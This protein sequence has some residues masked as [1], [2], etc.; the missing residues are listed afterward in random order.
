M[1][2][3]RS[4]GINWSF[5]AALAGLACL[6]TVF[7]IGLYIG[8]LN[9]PKEE[10]YQRYR[11]A[12]NQPTKLEVA[13]VIPK[14]ESF[15]YKEPCKNP[16]GRDESDLCAQWKAARAAERGALW[17]ER[18]VWITLVGAVGLFLTIIQGR[19]A[20]Q[21]AADA[22][23]IA[24]EIGQSQVRAQVYISSAR[25]IAGPIGINF[26]PKFSNS[27]QS[28]ALELGGDLSY[29]LLVTKDGKSTSIGSAQKSFGSMTVIKDEGR[30]LHGFVWDE[31]HIVS[32]IYKDFISK[33]GVLG[34]LD[35]NGIIRWQD[36]FGKYHHLIMS[37]TCNDFVRSDTEPRTKIGE[38]QIMHNY[39]DWGN[40]Q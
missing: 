35:I 32:E 22:N 39:L 24:S 21:R 27:G 16:E 29:N 1:V 6:F 8:A 10:R 25:I 7:G 28:M 23:K 5:I 9:Y 19:L 2:S 12:S 14:T 38:G 37:I 11:D 18:G 3:D 17:A 4:N 36:I 34:S 30:E 15:K 33:R 13:T 40:D 20:L 26:I 31:S